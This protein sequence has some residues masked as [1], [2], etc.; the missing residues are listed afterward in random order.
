MQEVEKSYSRTLPPMTSFSKKDKKLIKK[1][2]PNINLYIG[3]E[4]RIG[5]EDQPAG[6]IFLWGFFSLI[7][8]DFLFL[9]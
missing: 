7:L 9:T 4:L 3:G 8:Q 1:C 2:L 6:N 5:S